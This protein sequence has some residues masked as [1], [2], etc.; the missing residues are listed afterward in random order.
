MDYYTTTELDECRV[1]PNSEVGS[2][3]LR[4]CIIVERT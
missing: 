4:I 3:L 2:G 1:R